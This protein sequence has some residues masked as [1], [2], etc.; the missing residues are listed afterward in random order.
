MVTA[1]LTISASVGIRTSFQLFG[2]YGAWAKEVV[3]ADQTPGA[4]SRIHA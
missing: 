3:D 2:Q 4:A 1:R